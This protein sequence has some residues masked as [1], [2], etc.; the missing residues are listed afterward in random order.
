MQEGD[1]K[2]EVT[3]VGLQPSLLELDMF[4]KL[5][6]DTQYRLDRFLLDHSRLCN[7]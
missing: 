6:K 5:N 7:V 2:L 4:R 3:R 1:L